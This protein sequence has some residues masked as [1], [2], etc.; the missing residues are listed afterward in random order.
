G[1][2][3]EILVI[4]EVAQSYLTKLWNKDGV[5]INKDWEHSFVHLLG[6]YFTWIVFSIA[7]SG[8]V[9]WSVYDPSRIWNVVTAVLI[10]ACPCA[11]LLSNTFTNGNIL[12]R[13][14][15]NHFYLR[16]AQVIEDI[17]TADCIVFDKTGTLTTGRY[18]NIQYEGDDLSDK[19]K[20]QLGVLASQ[21][22]HPLSKAIV[23][24]CGIFHNQKVSGF[25]ELP[26][27]GIEGMID[28][29]LVL[30]GSKSFVTCEKSKTPDGSV[31]HIAFGE[32]VIGKFSFRN[33]YREHIPALLKFLG[34][35]YHLA[36]LS[37]DNAGEKEFLENMLGHE[38][39]LLFNQDP[40]DKLNA[41]KRLQDSGKKVIMVGDGLNDAGALQQANVGIAIS[42][43]NNHFTPASD[44][45][46]LAQELP[47][48]YRYI[49]LCKANKRVVL[50][51]FVISVL[52]NLAGIF[53]A[54]QGVMSPMIAAILMPCSSISILLITF[55]LSNYFSVRLQLK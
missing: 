8:A 28:G 10:V 54:V 35:K 5:G 22:T 3:I 48:L 2:N 46:L 50:A 36:V 9:Y 45:I 21:S 47:G 39:T 38:T 27:Y 6:R 26:G 1:S 55:G 53:F 49:Q 33:Q 30:L 51:A 44:A 12:R 7:F 19:Q 18:N 43:N 40:S 4:K 24:W 41:I 52:Y 37:G 17:A 29:D 14:G 25:K 34:A 31:V 20:Q 42:E 13:L 16:N 23:E 15:R 11:L 32:R